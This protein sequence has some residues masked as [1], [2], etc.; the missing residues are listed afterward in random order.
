VPHLPRL[1]G[2]L[3]PADAADVPRRGEQGGRTRSP[4]AGPRLGCALGPDLGVGGFALVSRWFCWGLIPSIWVFQGGLGRYIYILFFSVVVAVLFP[5]GRQPCVRAGRAEQGGVLRQ[6]MPQHGSPRPSPRPRCQMREGG[7]PGPG[8]GRRG[9]G[10][11]GKMKAQPPARPR[12]GRVRVRTG[13]CLSLF[14]AVLPPPQHAQTDTD[15]H[16]HLETHT[17]PPQTGWFYC[18]SLGCYQSPAH[19]CGGHSPLSVLP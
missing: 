19:G 8:V 9:P 12:D 10:W 13:E 2:L 11:R 18:I 7:V 5:R 6:G 16:R 4:A 14:S 17:G 3:V 1:S 15:R